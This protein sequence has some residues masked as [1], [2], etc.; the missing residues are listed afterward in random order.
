L[1]EDVKEPFL[2]EADEDTYTLVID[3]DETLV[4]Y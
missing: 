1:I 4:H 3:L 2:P